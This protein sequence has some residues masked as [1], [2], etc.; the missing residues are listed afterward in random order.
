M[1]RRK[2]LTG[3]LGLAGATAVATVARPFQAE[4]GVPA[5][6]GILGEL[7]V[8]AHAVDDGEARIEPVQDRRRRRRDD[9]RRGRRRREWRRVCR[10]VRD[11][12]GRRRTVCRR[13]RVWV[14]L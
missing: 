3:V 10:P 7:D 13:E 11:R 1:D 9:R 8:P 12:R 4:A 2:F 14:T 6:R 5:G